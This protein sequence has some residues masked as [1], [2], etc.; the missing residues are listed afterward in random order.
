MKRGHA[1]RVRL[2][3]LLATL[4]AGSIAICQAQPSSSRFTVSGIVVEQGTG[5]P[6]VMASVLIKEL[7]LWAVT[8]ER[9]RFELANVPAGRQRLEFDLLNP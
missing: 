8:D 2:V 6:V 5:A 7:D 9:G 4:V 3:I 1:C